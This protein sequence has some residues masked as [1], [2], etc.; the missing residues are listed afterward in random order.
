MKFTIA[1]T[2][3]I[4]IV[5]DDGD[6]FCTYDY[7]ECQL[8]CGYDNIHVSIDEVIEAFEVTLTELKNLK[9]RMEA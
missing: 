5:D 8:C 4:H 6:T 3:Q 2:S 9:E 1:P 7:D